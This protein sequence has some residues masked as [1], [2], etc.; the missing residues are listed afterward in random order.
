M[1]GSTYPAAPQTGALLSEHV[2]A[3]RKYRRHA[4]GGAR[5]SV[6][7]GRQPR[8]RALR[9]TATAAPTGRA[10]RIPATITSKCRPRASI[11][12]STSKNTAWFRFQADTG[13]QAA[14][15]DP[16]NPFFDALSPQPLYS[17][18]AG[19]THVFS[20]EPGELLQSGFFVV[21][22]PVCAQPISRRRSRP[23]P[24]V[25][26]GIGANAPF[27]TLG[28][29]DN[30]W[31]QGRRASRFFLNDNLAWSRGAHEFRFGTNTRIFRLNDY[32]FGEGTVPTV[33]YTDLPQFIYGVAS[34]ATQTFPLAAN[35]AFQLSESR[36]LRAGH[37]EGDAEAH[38]DLR[39]ARHA[40]LQSARIR[41]VR[42]RGLRGRSIPFRTTS[43]SR[44]TPP[45]KPHLGN[46]F[47]ST[48]LRDLAAANRARLAV[49]TADRAARPASEFSA[50]SCRA[51][52][53]T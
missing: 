42:S 1:T 22:E 23:F 17:F 37:L 27:T 21:R 48:P 39:S 8:P 14:Y 5:L 29:L 45:S 19:Y 7:R 34:T 10:F 13:V 25:L 41:I 52:S 44:S 46:L 30:T 11:T 16:I 2:F 32:D 51:A 24:I 26:Q 40:Q 20:S 50:T 53:R 15:T 49:C 36:S 28:G 18:A 12:I 33:T 6:Q 4:A 3:L 47:A 35:R 43:I 9:R 31:L 38:L